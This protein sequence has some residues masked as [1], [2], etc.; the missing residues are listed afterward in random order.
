IDVLI[1]VWI[2]SSTF[3]LHMIVSNLKKLVKKGQ[4]S[5]RK[6]LYKK[7]KQKKILKLSSKL[8]LTEM[9]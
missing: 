3:R 1:D 8:V 7:N 2:N 6:I 9:Q 5:K 4:W